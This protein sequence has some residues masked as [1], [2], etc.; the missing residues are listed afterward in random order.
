[1]QM[2][3]RLYSLNRG[4]TDFEVTEGVGNPVAVAS[5]D[6][7]FDLAAGLTRSEILMA[8]AAIK[9]HIISHNW[10]PA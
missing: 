4:Q 5:M 2:T 6:F 8:L 1:M 10:P 9:R 7:T 3:T